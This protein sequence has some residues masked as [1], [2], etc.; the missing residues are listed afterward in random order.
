MPVLSPVDLFLGQGLHA[1]KH[2][3]SEFSRTAHLLEFRRHVLTRRNDETFWQE[4]RIAVN[5][6]PVT[7][8]RLGVVAL[9]ITHVMDEFAPDAFAGI[10]CSQPSFLRQ[11]VGGMV[12]TPCCLPGFS[13]QQA[14]FAPSEGT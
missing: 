2:V 9:L 4:L 1:Y 6:D 14:V 10:Y 11:A 8:L 3:C 12:W 13:R 7:C 5:G